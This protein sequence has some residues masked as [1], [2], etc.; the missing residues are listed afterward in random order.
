MSIVRVSDMN[1]NGKVHL[2]NLDV[3]KILSATGIVFHHYQ[4]LTAVRWGGY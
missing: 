1:G 2:G 4:Q 3:I